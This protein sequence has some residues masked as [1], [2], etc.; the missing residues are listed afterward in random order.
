VPV[1]GGTKRG[2]TDRE[3]KRGGGLIG[4]K[5]FWESRSINKKPRKRT[6]QGSAIQKK[7]CLGKIGAVS[8]RPESKRGSRRKEGRVPHGSAPA[9]SERV[10]NNSTWGEQGLFSLAKQNRWEP[11]DFYLQ[12][13]MCC[14]AKVW[15]KAGPTWGQKRAEGGRLTF[16]QHIL[17]NTEKLR[18]KAKPDL[19][20]RPNGKGRG[21]GCD[22][23]RNVK[24]AGRKILKKRQHLKTECVVE[25]GAGR[26]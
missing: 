12:G 11:W 9:A 1:G 6:P 7:R 24:R 20:P 17:T 4:W 16:C 5:K 3:E 14:G 18:G 23:G 21:G 25:K 26:R 10:R 15:G 8:L 2:I 13:T 19:F 22:V